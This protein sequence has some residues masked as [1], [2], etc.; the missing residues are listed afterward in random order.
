MAASS[1][2][3]SVM[4]QR[5]LA[6]F[7]FVCFGKRGDPWQRVIKELVV[8]WAKLM[9]LQFERGHMALAY[10]WSKAKQAVVSGPTPTF[11][12][13]IPNVRILWRNVRAPPF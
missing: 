6:S 9:P 4:S 7:V 10:A 11:I 8:L 5:C 13:E 2:G 3:I 1:I 12:N